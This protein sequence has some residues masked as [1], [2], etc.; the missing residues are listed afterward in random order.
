MPTPKE[1]LCCLTTD[2]HIVEEPILLKCGGNACKKCIL[3]SNEKLIRCFSCEDKHE[4]NDFINAKI[5]E[6][7]ELII[8]SSL[9][10][11]FEDLNSKFE[12]ITIELKG[13]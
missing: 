9:G 10:S 13:I 2:R 12:A 1:I 5:N 4:Q 8:S 6:T 7:A 3:N 11:L